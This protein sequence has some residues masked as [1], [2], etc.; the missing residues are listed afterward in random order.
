MGRRPA[1][2][3]LIDVQVGDQIVRF[4]DRTL[5]TL[6]DAPA[7]V[8]DLRFERGVTLS[9]AMEYARLA[10]KVKREGKLAVPDTTFAS[11]ALCI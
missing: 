8:G 10:A 1:A 11:S 5:A 9:T 6:S 4:S 7:F 3:K 2:E